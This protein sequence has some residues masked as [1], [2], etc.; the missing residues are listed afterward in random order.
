MIFLVYCNLKNTHQRSIYDRF[1][2]E[3]TRLEAHLIEERYWLLR[4]NSSAEEIIS[5]LWSL[6]GREDCVF[7]SALSAS[8]RYVNAESGTN[9][10]L[11]QYLDHSAHS[12]TPPELY[13]DQK[14]AARF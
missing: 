3:L 8:Y 1:F 11:K 9:D 14:Q 10:W 7:V 5:K 13:E 4:S 2:N 6:V 12:K